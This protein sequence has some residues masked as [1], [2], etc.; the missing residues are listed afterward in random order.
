MQR[1]FTPWRFKYITESFPPDA[2]FFCDA[3]ADPGDESRLVVYVGDHHLVMLNKYP[4]TNGHLLIAP[5]KHIANP[6]QAEEKASHELWPMVLRAIRVLEK[7]YSPQG[8]NL[9]MN[10]GTAGGAG[11]PGHYHYHVVPRW[12][13]DTNF[14][15]VLGDTRLLPEE[16]GAVITRLKPL[17]DQEEA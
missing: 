1:L 6:L 15:T 8:F 7:A 16:P 9:G 14:M 12:S 3:A 13:G 4:Y 5:L 11:V 10:L 17:F 2:C